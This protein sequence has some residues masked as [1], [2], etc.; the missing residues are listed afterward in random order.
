M[1]LSGRLGT[2]AGDRA[3]WLVLLA[4]GLGVLLPA[5]C[6]IWFMTEAAGNQADAA[7]QRLTDSLRGQLQLLRDRIDGDWRARL[8]RLRTDG[9]GATAFRR[10]VMSGEVDAVVFRAHDGEAGYPSLVPAAPE[11]SST[12]ASTEWKLALA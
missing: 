8:A 5:A 7:R 10:A 11:R 4:L 2:A 6:V 12:D 3:T 1:R 9:H